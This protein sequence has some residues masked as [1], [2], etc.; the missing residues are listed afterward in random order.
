MSI[1]GKITE[2]IPERRDR[3]NFLRKEYGD[4]KV[5]EV[6]VDQIY[7]GI[8][9]VQISVSD[10]SYVDP[11]EGIRLRGYSIPEVLK[12]LPKPKDSAFP[13]SGGLYYLL[14]TDELPTLEDALEVEQE[15]KIRR[16]VPNH[17]Y[18][19]LNAM[20][21]STHPMTLFSQAI[22][23][24]QTDSVFAKHYS[25]IMPKTTYW[26]YFLEDSLNLTARLPEI[27]AY[28]YNRKCRAGQYIPPNPDL[29]WSANFAHMIGMGDSKEYTELSRLYFV[30]HA[31]HEG[32]N[33]SAHASSLVGS[34][35]SD[36][37]MCS[38]A[39]MNGL[40]GP[41]HGLANQECLQWLL[42]TLDHFNGELPDDEQ[43][44][45]YLRL[46]LNSGHTIPGYGHAVLR[47][48]DPRFT[49]LYQFAESNLP[50][51]VNFKLVK[52]VYR[53]L[54]GILTEMGKVKNPWPNVDAI[55]GAIQY[56]YGVKEFDFYTV[57][58]GVS[59]ILGLSAHA[60]WARAQMKPIERPKSL[61]MKM[62]EDMVGINHS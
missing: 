30:L 22:M 17:V 38:A 32:A 23:A 31:D 16:K 12:L 25:S 56:H 24:M 14:M 50:D 7:G 35:L 37:Y 6:T 59:R 39:G 43:L 10:I 53:V 55:G 2:K 61:T 46:L 54:P 29:D 5:S 13:Y 20:P 42:K 44:S 1:K 27:A 40:A 3:M 41:L 52:Q 33:V 18:D 34:A 11:Q 28:I 47:I 60:V 36:I 8:R 9:G 57:L 15:W 19:V 49:A 45:K 4:F 51:D 62:L 48:P 58:F 21:V 26:E